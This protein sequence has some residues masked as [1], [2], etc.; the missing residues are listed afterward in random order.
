[1]KCFFAAM[2]CCNG[3]G[4]GDSDSDEMRL[5]FKSKTVTIIS[6]REAWDQKISES[7]RDGKIVVAN[8]SASWCGPCKL[9]APL[10]CELSEKFPSIMFLVI[11]VDAL[12]EFSS[13]WDIRATPTF[14]F[15]R[16]GKQI[17]KLIGANKPDLEK[18]I[19]MLVGSSS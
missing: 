6:G 1:M 3:K 15:L 18:K 5:E 14:F 13:S 4:G 10:Y 19:N 12:T 17:D 7:K 9:M 2:F 11:D 8:F 16:D